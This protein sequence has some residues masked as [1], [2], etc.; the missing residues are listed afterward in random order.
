MEHKATFVGKSPEN[1]R[2]PFF[3]HLAARVVAE[4]SPSV[5]AGGGGRG[6]GGK[7]RGGRRGL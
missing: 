7:G 3:S 5:H 6:E 2:E 1:A 4:K